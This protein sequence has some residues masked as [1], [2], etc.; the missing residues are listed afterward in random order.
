MGASR[1]SQCN[2]N[3]RE[4]S[5]SKT[6]TKKKAAQ[7]ENTRHTAN[8][9]QETNNCI[10]KAIKKQ[11]T[12]KAR[13]IGFHFPTRTRRASEGLRERTKKSFVPPDPH[14]SG[15]EKRRERRRRR[16]SRRRRCSCGG[17]GSA[18]KNN[19]YSGQVKRKV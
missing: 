9:D 10:D 16:Q 18:I 7:H 1:N 14:Q 19:K 8:T 15:C 3:P 4:N 17:G 2:R 11:T 12:P 6:K 13:P 5:I